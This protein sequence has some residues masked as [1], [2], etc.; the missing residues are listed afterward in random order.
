MMERMWHE[1]LERFGRETV[2]HGRE[3][4]LH[5]RAMIQPCLDR[6]EQQIPGPLGLGRQDRSRYMGPDSCPVDLDTVVE[7]E[8]REYRVLSAH[9][10]GDGICPYWWALLCPREEGAL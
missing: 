9:R 8:G 6:K 3:G 2:L 5:V 4:D 1:I 10:M 7:Q